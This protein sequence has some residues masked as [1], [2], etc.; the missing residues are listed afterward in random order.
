ML[1]GMNM[2]MSTSFPGDRPILARRPVGHGLK[3]NRAYEFKQQ[4]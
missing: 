1:L 2:S 4:H 3:N